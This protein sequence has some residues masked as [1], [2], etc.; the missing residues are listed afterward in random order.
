MQRNTFKIFTLI[1]AI[2]VAG[3]TYTDPGFTSGHDKPVP[4]TAGL[5]SGTKAM[6]DVGHEGVFLN[7]KV[8]R[9][10]AD[11]HHHAM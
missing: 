7:G 10:N 1:G 5:N 9:A 4:Q 11:I 2:S 6:R 3:F 8:A